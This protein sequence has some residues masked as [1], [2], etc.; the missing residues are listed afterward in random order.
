MI[1]DSHGHAPNP[2]AVVDP[3]GPPLILRIGNR[4][5][6]L[7][8]P[9]SK[10]Q[11]AF[12]HASERE[13]LY[14]GAKRGGK[15]WAI[16]LKL[17]MLA[18]TFPGNLVRLF[19]QD[20][21]DLR[22]STLV[23]WERLV[24]SE[25]ILDHHQTHRNF[26][27]RT[28]GKPSVV[29]YDGLKDFRPNDN[30]V[31]GWEH[32]AFA[33]DEP[34]EVDPE[35][36]RMLLAQ[37]CWVLPDGNRPPYMAILGSNPEPGWVQDRFDSLI[38]PTE[39]DPNLKQVSNGK[40][41]FVKALPIDNP[42]LPTNWQEDAELDAPK[43]WVDKYLKGSWRVSTG[44]VFKEWDDDI[45][46]IDMPPAEYL[47][48]LRL[49]ASIDHADTGTTA[50]VIVGIDADDNAV[51][52]Y[53]YY[54]KDKL[55]SAHAA[56]MSSLMDVA[57]MQCGKQGAVN[58]ASRQIGVVPSFYGFEYIL[59]DPSTQAKVLQGKT[60]LYSRL[61]EYR[62]NG[63]PAIPAINALETGLNLV[64][65]YIHIKPGHVHPLSG[66]RGSPSLFVVRKNCPNLRKNIIGLKRTISDRGVVRYVGEDHA[67]DNLRYILMSRP[68]PPARTKKDILTMNSHDQMA[69]RSHDKWAN[70][71][72]KKSESNLWWGNTIQ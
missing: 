3:L 26:L 12:I 1:Y 53:E 6:P 41:I 29:H 64:G 52:L 46:L 36:Y 67:L 66:L 48:S 18:V 10:Q 7:G 56:G 35:N 65:E 33:I 60:E 62:R 63:I 25:I 4:E 2:G 47:S 14:G 70:A 11:T 51:A 68:E 39:D 59:I 13:Q 57:V 21:T 24:P 17:L 28:N 40:Q 55:I 32:G 61:D 8:A 31:Q 58:V 43:E 30:S 20:L 15:S 71:F 42:Y 23:T 44:Q 38:E 72:G 50:M 49:V 69:T 22:E 5:Y 16:C 19:R 9:P 34:S 54:V 45:H 27:I 37:L